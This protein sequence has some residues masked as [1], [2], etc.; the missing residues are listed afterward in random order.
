[1]NW[2]YSDGTEKQ[3][4][5]SDEAFEKVLPTLPETTLIWTE[6]MNHWAPLS[7][8]PSKSHAQKSVFYTDE[9]AGESLPE[10]HH[11]CAVSGKIYPETQMIRFGSLWVSQE[12][13]EV[14]LAKIRAGSA[15]PGTFEYAGFLIRLG[16]YIIDT[17]I[18]YILLAIALVIG[19]VI[20]LPDVN[21]TIPE[22]MNVTFFIIQGGI[23]LITMAI[24]GIYFVLFTGRYGAT[25]GKM[26]CGLKIVR[27]NGNP[28]GYTL[29][30][31]RYLATILSGLI[32][33]IGYLM[34]LFDKQKRALH[35]FLCDTRVIHIS[36]S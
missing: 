9:K 10:G 11:V 21:Q 24:T 4:P 15:V 27:A 14:Y 2:Y 23:M 22:D 20:G 29:A 12:Y 36:K 19:R 32:L 17:I 25:P 1:M 18:I 8:F 13:K 30:L 16:A 7:S 3:G 34:I 31:L 33:Y 26:V 35:D 6:G 5:F 28:M